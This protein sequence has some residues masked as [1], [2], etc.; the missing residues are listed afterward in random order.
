MRLKHPPGAYEP[1]GG[2]QG[3]FHVLVRQGE[4]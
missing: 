3:V 2:S 1:L 4:P